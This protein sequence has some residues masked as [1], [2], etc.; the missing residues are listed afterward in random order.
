VYVYGDH[1]LGESGVQVR[2][3]RSGARGKKEKRK[4]SSVHVWGPSS[5]GKRRAGER[6]EVRS[7]GQKRRKSSV[8][9]MY[10]DHRLGESGVQ[11]RDLRSGAKGKKET[12]NLVYSICIGTIVWGKAACR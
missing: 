7:E 2:D 6:L 10:G 9:Y 11:V 12:K 4:K 5:G 8:Q 1:R 3:L